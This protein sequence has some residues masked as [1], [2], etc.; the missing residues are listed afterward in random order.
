MGLRSLSAARVVPSCTMYGPLIGDLF[1]LGS[2]I[3]SNA[4]DLRD[5]NPLI[6]LVL[7]QTQ[8]ADSRCRYMESGI[9][10]HCINKTNIRTHRSFTLRS[11]LNLILSNR[12]LSPSM[13]ATSPTHPSTE[14][15]ST[16]C[17]RM[18]SRQTSELTSLTS[19]PPSSDR[20]RNSL[21]WQRSWSRNVRMRK[22][23]FT[24]RAPVGRSGLPAQ[25][26]N[27]CWT[28]FKTSRSILRYGST[29]EARTL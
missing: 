28:G 8:D 21:S 14:I 20:S 16:T 23:R 29:T 22:Y 1:G 25:R 9:K 4:L 2:R 10:P 19:S 6:K 15:R 5:T 26:R 12:R 13:R 27:L 17:Q 7:T 24:K 11:D 18:N 3:P